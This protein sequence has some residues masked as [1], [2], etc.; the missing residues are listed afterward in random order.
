MANPQP[1]DA[2]IRIAHSISEAIMTRNFSKRQRA[3]L[4]LVLRLSW[5]CG[6]KFAIIPKQKDFALVGIAES[7][8]RSELE[9]LVSAGVIEWDKN[10][11]SIS[12]KKDFDRWA[13]SLVPGYNRQRL[14]ELIHINL[15]S[16]NGNKIDEMGI[17]FPKKRKKLPE[18]PEVLDH[19]NPDADWPEGVSKKSIKESNIYTPDFERFY[20]LYPRAQEKQRTFKNWKTCLKKH[21]PEELI[22]AAIN[23]KAK[24]EGTEKKF[25][26]TSANFLGR[27]KFYLDYI[28]IQDTETDKY[29]DVKR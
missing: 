28:E 23:Y 1:N 24:V 8:I 20:F 15:T 14:D 4:D 19:E 18:M 6:K 11:N 25:I 29:S 27:D 10:T 22:R 12:F 9:W 13:V 3:I 26:K 21:K 2:H 16:Q 7:K 17:N 5:G